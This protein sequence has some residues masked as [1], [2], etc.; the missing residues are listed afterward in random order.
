MD[1]INNKDNEDATVAV[2]FN[3]WCPA[4]VQDDI[5]VC[6]KCSH[7]LTNWNTSVPVFFK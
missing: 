2:N 5:L 4:C 7:E 6:E 1:E 3:S